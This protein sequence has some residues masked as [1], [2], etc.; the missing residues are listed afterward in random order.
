MGR[1]RQTVPDKRIDFRLASHMEVLRVVL[2]SSVIVAGLRGRLG[3]SNRLSELAGEGIL[4]RRRRH[5][6]R[7][8]QSMGQQISDPAR[9]IH[10]GLASRDVADVLSVGQ[11][12]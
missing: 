2:A 9:I 4:Y 11:G 1:C 12:R 7:T 10:V 6:A 3:A 5:K 8:D